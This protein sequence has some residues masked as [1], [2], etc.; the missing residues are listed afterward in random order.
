M[1]N[2]AD[3][4]NRKE[5]RKRTALARAAGLLGRLGGKARSPAKT[6]AA[7]ANARKPRRRGVFT[8]FCANCGH[9]RFATA[10]KSGGVRTLVRC[11][12]CGQLHGYCHRP[13]DET[14]TKKDAGK[15]KTTR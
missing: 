13:I 15:C 7:R 1:P 5:R 12:R 2:P 8:Y 10:K 14:K 11:R 9:D 3:N 6:A 4:P